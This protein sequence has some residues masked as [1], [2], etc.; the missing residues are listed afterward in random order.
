MSTEVATGETVAS[1]AAPKVSRLP[2]R[3]LYAG[4][5]GRHRLAD[6]LN[7]R[8][9]K[10]SPS[11][12]RRSTAQST[13]QVPLWVLGLTRDK[14]RRTR[15]SYGLPPPPVRQF[16]HDTVHWCFR[17]GRSFEDLIR[18]LRSGQA[19][20]MKDLEPHTLKVYFWP[21]HDNRRLKCLKA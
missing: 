20:P 2:K 13:Q 14:I 7:M 19:D 16:T 17:D 10:G 9:E 1:R 18:N 8:L 21:V 11:S 12:A 15:E 3:E 5:D 6:R 4:G